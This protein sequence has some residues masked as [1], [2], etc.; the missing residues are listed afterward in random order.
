M[1]LET[2]A[3]IK[4]Y[5][6][7][8][9]KTG[10][11]ILIQWHGGEPTA[12]GSAWFKEAIETINYQLSSYVVIH[13]IQTNL[14]NYNEKWKEIYINH[15]NASI[16]VSWDAEIRLM[17]RGKPESNRE[18]ESIFWDKLGQLH[19]DGIEPYLVVTG[20]KLFFEKF[21]NP[22][23]LFE[24][25][26][27]KGIKR[28]HIER[29]TKTGYARESW[30]RIGVSNLE[31]SEYMIKIARAYEVYSKIPPK[32]SVGYKVSISPLDGLNESV[33]RLISGKAGGYG[34]LS[35]GCDSNFHTFDANGYKKGCT[36]INSEYDNSKSFLGEGVQVIQFFDLKQSRNERQV[37]CYS[38]EFKP[39]CSSGCLAT[40]KTDHSGECSGS[41]KLF[42]EI[43]RLKK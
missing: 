16:G 24:F 3:G 27:E 8:F 38:C 29:L 13:G 9:A 36:A 25:L 39:I 41:F 19:N 43:K 6:S 5:I 7:Q 23:K 17:K 20:T 37:D 21:K 32:E 26:E 31:Y 2:L 35:G 15:F 33:E 28:C 12:M 34:C 10:D 40:P 18:Y 14:I 22:Y 11:T 30:D 4:D 42:S 1:T